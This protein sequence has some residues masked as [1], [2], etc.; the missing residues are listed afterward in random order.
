MQPTS[1]VLHLS[2]T[3]FYNNNVEAGIEHYDKNSGTIDT[4]SVGF[5]AY[6]SQFQVGLGEDTTICVGDTLV[7]DATITGGEYIWQ[8]GSTNATYNVVV[9]DTYMVTVTVG[10]CEVSDTIIVDIVANP[11]VN[12]GPDTTICPYDSIQL[13]ALWP[14]SNY[15]WNNGSNDSIITIGAAGTYWVGSGRCRL[16]RCRY[17]HS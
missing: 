15:S 9:G 13:N 11:V 5:N 1:A 4:S 16:H 3:D 10:S 2:N 6:Y 14:S 7:L 12:L 17:Y 8:D